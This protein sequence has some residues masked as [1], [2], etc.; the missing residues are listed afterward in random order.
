MDSDPKFMVFIL[1]ITNSLLFLRLYM[2]SRSLKISFIKRGFM[3]FCVLNISVIRVCKFFV[4][5][6][7]DLSPSNILSKTSPTSPSNRNEFCLTKSCP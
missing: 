7:T 3:L 6:V 4:W 1:G 5:V 2:L